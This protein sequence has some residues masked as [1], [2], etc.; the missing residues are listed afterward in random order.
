MIFDILI[1]AVSTLFVFIGT[2]LPAAPTYNS[3]ITTNID[4]LANYFFYF[5]QLIAIDTLFLAIATVI[6]LEMIIAAVNIARWIIRSI[7]FLNSRI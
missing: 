6:S 3:T 4:T 5:D 2:F 1:A 7:P